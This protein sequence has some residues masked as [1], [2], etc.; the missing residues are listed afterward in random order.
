VFGENFSRIGAF[1]RYNEPGRAFD[2]AVD[3]GTAAPDKTAELFVEAGAAMNSVRI[4]LDATS[5]FTKSNTG[6]HFA[7]GARRAV[8]ERSDLGARLELDD[9]NHHTLLS[10]RAIDYRYRF[11]NP[12]AFSVFVGA[13][14]YNLATPAYGLYYGAGLQWRDI[15]PGWD[16][17]V[18]V[19]N[20]K[21]VARD[22]LLPNDPS[23]ALRPDSF[24]TVTSTGLAITKR[25]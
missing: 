2:S 10:V 8:S 22:H 23:S 13:S 9:V 21:K 24:Y 5:P 1:F 12:L 14:R 19:R 3:Y 15:A 4:D 20:A 25:F 11:S 17:G 6:A 18:D 16:I 7:V